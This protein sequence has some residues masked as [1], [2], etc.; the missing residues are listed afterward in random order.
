ARTHDIGKVP[1]DE[2]L[3]IGESY[4]FLTNY[5]Q[6]PETYK[7]DTDWSSA[8]N[9]ILLRDAIEAITGLTVHRK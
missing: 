9:L 8:A 7:K 2:F 1:S 6:E 5:E 4:Y 3:K